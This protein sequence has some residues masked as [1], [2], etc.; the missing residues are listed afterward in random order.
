MWFIVSSMTLFLGSMY[1]GGF[2]YGYFVSVDEWERKVSVRH[3]QAGVI[4]LAISFGA[5]FFIGGFRYPHILIVILALI[6]FGMGLV[7]L[8]RRFSRESGS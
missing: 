4:Y 8:V 1:L 6:I 2:G 5:S 3:L 7:F